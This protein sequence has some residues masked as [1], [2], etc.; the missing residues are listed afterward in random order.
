M[1]SEQ[2][3]Q[4]LATYQEQNV[5][6]VYICT[7]NDVNGNPRRSYYDLK[8]GVFYD[9]GYMGHHAVPEHLRQDA[10]EA[11]YSYKINLKPRQYK[12]FIKVT[13]NMK[14]IL[15]DFS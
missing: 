5:R 11:E 1:F 2:F 13:N 14:K 9:E 10:L 8:E 15:S 7:E 3:F 6:I 12:L 4:T